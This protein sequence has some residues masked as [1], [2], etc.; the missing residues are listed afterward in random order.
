MHHTSKLE[1]TNYNDRVEEN[2][3]TLG[4]ECSTVN[5]LCKN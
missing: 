1:M 2:K 5:V 3:N 4:I